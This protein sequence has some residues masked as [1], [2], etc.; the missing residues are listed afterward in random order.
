L[1]SLVPETLEF[2]SPLLPG[3][4]EGDSRWALPDRLRMLAEVCEFLLTTKETTPAS[5]SKP[6]SKTLPNDLL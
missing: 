4:E 1:Q 3:P 2:P 5:T 6:E